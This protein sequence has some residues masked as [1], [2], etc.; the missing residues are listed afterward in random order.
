MLL[1]ETTQWQIISDVK[2]R[3]LP[4]FS[5]NLQVET[6]SQMFLDTEIQSLDAN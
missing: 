2:I 4:L 5:N 1:Q 6:P 3:L